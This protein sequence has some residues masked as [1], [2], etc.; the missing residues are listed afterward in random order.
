M[1]P[2]GGSSDRATPAM[3]LIAHRGWAAG[4][5]ENTLIA[6]VRAAGD[7]RISGVEL[8]VRRN[9]EGALV[10]SHDPPLPD[11][12][13]L[14]AALEFLAPTR[15]ELLVELKEPGLDQPVIDAL[16][17]HKLADRSVVFGFEPIAR[18]FRWREPRAVRL[19]IIA[20]YPWELDRMTHA[21]AP[22]MLLLGWDYRPWTRVAF[23]CWWSVFSLGALARRHGVPVV[24]GI[25]NR[26]RD[27]HWLSRQGID[28]AVADIDR[29]GL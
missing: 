15:L 22:D 28:A 8:D 1:P 27:I 10:V 17:A 19:G 5:E 6:F 7:A 12:L 11:I 21:H 26:M 2:R 16:V 20:L 18:S 4:A 14:E 3:K 9:A 13:T 25:V 29:L 23:Q 24:I